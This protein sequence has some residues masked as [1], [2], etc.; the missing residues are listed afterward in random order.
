MGF[1]S[2]DYMAGWI[3]DKIFGHEDPLSGK[4]ANGSLDID[5]QNCFGSGQTPKTALYDLFQNYTQYQVVFP[6]HPEP[7]LSKIFIPKRRYLT[8][9]LNDWMI[10]QS[11]R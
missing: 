3:V 10:I 1:P 8:M 9:L 6:Q 4:W 7:F 5:A 2:P 11:C